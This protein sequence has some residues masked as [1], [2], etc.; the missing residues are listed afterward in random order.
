LTEIYEK[1][2]CADKKPPFKGANF[3][4]DI[5][6]PVH[7]VFIDSNNQQVIN[8]P[9]GIKIFGGYSVSM[10]QKSFAI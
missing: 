9:A 4:K 1:G 3:W 5:E 8:E 2:C 7:V 10:P 6:K